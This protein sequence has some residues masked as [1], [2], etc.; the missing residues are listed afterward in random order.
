MSGQ[1]PTSTARQLRRLRLELGLPFAA[2]VL[3]VGDRFEEG[4]RYVQLVID[5]HAQAVWDALDYLN[6]YDRLEREWHAKFEPV[7]D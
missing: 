2:E 1:P 6:A 7:G 3:L 4:G 5:E